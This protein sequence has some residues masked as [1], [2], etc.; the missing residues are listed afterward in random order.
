MPGDQHAGLIHQQ[1]VSEA[2]S[3]HAGL[4]LLQLLGAMHAGVASMR[5]QLRNRAQNDLRRHPGKR[6]GAIQ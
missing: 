3:Q 6:H 2:E 1:W 4:D 5:A